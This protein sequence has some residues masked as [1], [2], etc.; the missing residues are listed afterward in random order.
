MARVEQFLVVYSKAQLLTKIAGS[1]YSKDV[2]E[3][4]L[5]ELV[6]IDNKRKKRVSLA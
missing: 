4:G 6:T 1:L 2:D 5:R 3:E